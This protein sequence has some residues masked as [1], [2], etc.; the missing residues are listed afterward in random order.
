MLGSFVAQRR[1][2]LLVF[3]SI[4][5]H[6]QP[7]QPGGAACTS[8]TRIS[9]RSS[10]LVQ[11]EA[12]ILGCDASR[13]GQPNQHHCVVLRRPSCRIALRSVVALAPDR[14]FLPVRTRSQRRCDPFCI[15]FADLELD[16]Q[17]RLLDFIGAPWVQTV[18]VDS[19]G[20]Q[21]RIIAASRREL[22]SEVL[23]RSFAPISFTE[24]TSYCCEFRLSSASRRLSC[25]LPSLCCAIERFDTAPRSYAFGKRS[26]GYAA[27]TM[28]R[29][30][31]GVI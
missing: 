26:I 2:R 23:P 3:R 18:S 9:A 25:Y 12:R 6:G 13:L 30:R 24:S 31:T 14:P 19:E 16:A 21:A 7:H 1:M 15:M 27:S 22:A 29:Q 28:I 5:S 11:F 8:I 17:A 10:V 4:S 20:R